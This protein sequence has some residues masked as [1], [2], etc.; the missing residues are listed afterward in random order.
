[1]KRNVTVYTTY[2][3]S[4]EEKEKTR[5]MI[6][7]ENIKFE[8]CPIIVSRDNGLDNPVNTGFTK[9][10]EAEKFFESEKENLWAERLSIIKNRTIVKEAVGKYYDSHADDWDL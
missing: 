4:E 2:E 5:K 1:M 7:A 8:L 9:M 3:L 6:S 10:E